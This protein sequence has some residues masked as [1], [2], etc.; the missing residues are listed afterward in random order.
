MSHNQQPGGGSQV[1]SHRHRRSQVLC[2][3]N[4]LNFVRTPE[5]WE[6]V[7]R[8]N[9]SQGV[10]IL[11]VTDDHHLLL[12]EQL[13]PPLGGRTIELP[14]GV[15]DI[16]ESP[17]A[18]ARRELEEETGYRSRSIKQIF[19]GSTSPGITDDQNTICIASGLRR[20]DDPARD[21]KFADG[22]KRHHQVRGVTAENENLLV[23]EVPLHIVPKW[24]DRRRRTGRII[25]LRVYAGL[26]LLGATTSESSS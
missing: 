19:S 18:A 25:D 2:R 21:E 16:D 8:H 3:G 23:W 22:S 6:Y 17:R 26:Y 20:I 12:T 24:L 14:A 7:Y 10:I 1:N 5:G 9:L 13:R 15:T 4:H 11:A